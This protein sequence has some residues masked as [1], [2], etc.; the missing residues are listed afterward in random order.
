MSTSRISR[1]LRFIVLASYLLHF[2]SVLGVD[3]PRRVGRARPH[4]AWRTES[5]LYEPPCAFQNDESQDLS[6]LLLFYLRETPSRKGLFQSSAPDGDDP[7]MPPP[8]A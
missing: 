1:A 8:R 4:E 2:F 3:L 6:D 5:D 7:A